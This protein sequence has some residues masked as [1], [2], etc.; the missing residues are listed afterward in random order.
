M[1]RANE[2]SQTPNNTPNNKIAAKS[3]VKI[4]LRN[5]IANPL[6]VGT[7][8][9]FGSPVA[10]LAVEGLLKKGVSEEQKEKFAEQITRTNDIDH[11]FRALCEGNLPEQEQNVL[12]KSFNALFLKTKTYLD[13]KQMRWYKRMIGR[14]FEGGQI[15]GLIPE[16]DAYYTLAS[17]YAFELLKNEKILSTMAK[18]ALIGVIREH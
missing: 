10:A 17:I 16:N 7:R 8:T 15:F 6:Q 2:N 12:V 18:C 9:V 14:I 5:I 3:R 13:R 11:I 4:F 1:G